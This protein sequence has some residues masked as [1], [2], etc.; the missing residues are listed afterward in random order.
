[1]KLIDLLNILPGYIQIREEK[2][3]PCG[4]KYTSAK[5]IKLEITKL[6]NLQRDGAMRYTWDISYYPE[7]SQRGVDLEEVLEKVVNRLVK[8]GYIKEVEDANISI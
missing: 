4:C 7:I 6:N 8:F 2:K 1:M 5:N 3:H